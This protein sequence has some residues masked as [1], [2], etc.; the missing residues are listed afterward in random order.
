M[1]NKY[2]WRFNK[3]IVDIFNE[4]IRK[5]IPLYD[6][7][8][9]DIADMSVYF[10]QSGSNIIDI[11]TSTGNL[12]N[13]LYT[14]NN[15]RNINFIGIDNE[16]DMINNCLN[17]YKNIN[18]KLCDALDYD[19]TNSSIVTSMLSLQFMSKNKRKSL[20][21]NIYKGL[22][23]DGVLFIVEKVKNDIID[24]HDIYN[25]IYYDFKRLNLNDTEILDKNMS[26]RGIMKPLTLKENIEMLENAGFEKID[27]F[28]KK[29]NFVGIISIK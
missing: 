17:Q 5:S 3:E 20:I 23:E 16:T 1:Y 29:L 8:Q 12:I 14:L 25:D 13:K 4:H 21:E 7:I 19:Y 22:N 27:I 24:I 28:F 10:S 2:N 6:D 26:I 18:F 11:G 9:K 15:N